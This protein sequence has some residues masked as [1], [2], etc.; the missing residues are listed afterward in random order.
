MKPVE[1][2]VRDGA[3]IDR[4]TFETEDVDVKKLAKLRRQIKNGED[5]VMNSGATGFVRAKVCD[6]LGGEP[7]YEIRAEDPN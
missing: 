5:L 1:I 6:W 4:Y 3:G 7:V 2:L